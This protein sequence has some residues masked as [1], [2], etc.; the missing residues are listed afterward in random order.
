MTGASWLDD[1]AH[2]HAQRGRRARRRHRVAAQ[3]HRRWRLLG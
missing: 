3:A 1:P 2:Q